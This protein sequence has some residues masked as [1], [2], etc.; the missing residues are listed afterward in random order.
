M[1]GNGGA[2]SRDCR[3]DLRASMVG[4]IRMSSNVMSRSVEILIHDDKD[5]EHCVTCRQQIVWTHYKAHWGWW[6]G[7]CGCSGRRW[8]KSPVSVR[9]ERFDNGTD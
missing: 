5:T 9:V 2:Y 7:S 1:S 4:S 6:K 8:E 3:F